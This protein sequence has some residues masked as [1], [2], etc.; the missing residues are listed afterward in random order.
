MNA[1]NVGKPSLTNL[2]LLYITKFTEERN[3]MSAMNVGRPS[4][5]N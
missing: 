2:S 5:R 1:V 4:F 3:P